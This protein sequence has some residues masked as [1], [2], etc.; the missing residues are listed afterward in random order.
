MSFE[1]SVIREKIEKSLVESEKCVNSVGR[2]V[3]FHMTAWIEELIRMGQ[4]FQAPEKFNSEEVSELI[5]DFL[6]KVPEHLSES[7]RLLLK[8]EYMVAKN[9]L[10]NKLLLEGELGLDEKK[11][12]EANGILIGDL[13]LGIQKVMGDNKYYPINASLWQPGEEVYDG[14]ILERTNDGTFRVYLQKARDLDAFILSESKAYQYEDFEMAAESFIRFTW[15]KN[16]NG[17]KINWK[18]ALTA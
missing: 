10:I 17:V 15:G 2:N 4:F 8:D 5:Q 13:V 3:A 12:F 6:S 16:I 18:G 9:D 7:A 1:P 11:F 14:A